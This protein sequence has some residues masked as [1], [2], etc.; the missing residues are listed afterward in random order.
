M[1]ERFERAWAE[2]VQRVRQ[3]RRGDDPTPVLEALAQAVVWHLVDAIDAVSPEDRAA[4]EEI[5]PAAVAAAREQAMAGP[6]DREAWLEAVALAEL[7]RRLLGGEARPDLAGLPSDLR[8]PTPRRLAAMLDGRLDGLSAATCAVWCLRHAP[9]EARLLW[10]LGGEPV[11]PAAGE[12]EPI[13]VAAAEPEPMRAPD[14]GRVVA[15]LG[16]P[17]VEAVWFA[18]DRQLALYAADEVYVTFTAPGVTTRDL[19]PGYWLGTV[20]AP[21]TVALSGQLRVGDRVSRWDLSLD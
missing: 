20:D 7:G 17:A 12:D 14:E 21:E 10:T 15:T 6:G 3:W 16:A 13:L 11:E 2:R 1:R 9:E 5:A 18:A 4:L 8:R 19:R